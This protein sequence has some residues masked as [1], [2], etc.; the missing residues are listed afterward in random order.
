[1]AVIIGMSSTVKGKKFE[2][3][4]GETHIGRQSQN[5]IPIDDAS[6]SGRHCSVVREDRRYFN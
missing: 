6:I 4:E 1:M 2:L 3:A 5:Q